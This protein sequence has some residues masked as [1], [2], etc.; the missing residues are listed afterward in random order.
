MLK[1]CCPA[2][3]VGAARDGG[4][5]DALQLV[6]LIE[7]MFC[8]AYSPLATSTTSRNAQPKRRRSYSVV[9]RLKKCAL[10]GSGVRREGTS[11]DG[12]RR[13]RQNAERGHPAVSDVF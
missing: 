10:I 9:L 7:G 12:Q 1:Y 3:N 5:R 4:A 11:D 13:S 8:I 6:R 2:P